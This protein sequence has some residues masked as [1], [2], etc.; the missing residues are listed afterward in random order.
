MHGV[1]GV[2]VQNEVELEFRSIVEVY[3]DD[4]F[5]LAKENADGQGDYK[6]I[7]LYDGIVLNPD[8]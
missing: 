1:Q 3:R 4:E 7:A 6:N 8:K 5:V 2:W